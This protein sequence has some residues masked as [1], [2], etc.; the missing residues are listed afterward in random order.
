MI[1]LMRG[2]V[3]GTNPHVPSLPLELEPLMDNMY[4]TVLSLI[5]S[6]LRGLG[7][8][9]IFYPAVKHASSFPIK[10]RNCRPCM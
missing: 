7:L 8:D 2:G 3:V 10:L 6:N 9:S 1:L 4:S 5:A